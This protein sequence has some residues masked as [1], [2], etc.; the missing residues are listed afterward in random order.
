MAMDPICHVSTVQAGGEGGALLSTLS[1]VADYSEGYFQQDKAPCH[2]SQVNLNCFLQ[3]DNDFIVLNLCQKSPNL[4]QTEHLW[5]VVGQKICIMNVQ[6]GNL[7]LRDAVMLVKNKIYEECFR[8]L[9]ES[10][11]QIIKLILEAKG[12]PACC[13]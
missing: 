7:Q 3:H 1:I 5:N 13:T 9:A 8:H 12:G 6:P 4:Q 11:P 10:L 2:K